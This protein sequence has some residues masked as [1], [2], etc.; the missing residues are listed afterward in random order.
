M[1]KAT[2]INT[3]YC[4]AKVERKTLCKFIFFSLAQNVGLL[5]LCTSFLFQLTHEFF[6][7]SFLWP[8]TSP[9]EYT[10]L[11]L[12]NHRTKQPPLHILVQYL[13]SYQSGSSARTELVHATTEAVDEKINS[14]RSHYSRGA[15]N[16]NGN[17]NGS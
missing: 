16:S 10:K 4:N 14:C 9:Q 7:K 6:M 5:F 12:C 15:N 17:N 13:A 2:K 11:I 1:N 8:F 3:S